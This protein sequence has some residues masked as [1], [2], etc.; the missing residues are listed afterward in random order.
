MWTSGH[1]SG[2]NQVPNRLSLAVGAALQ[3][4]RCLPYALRWRGVIHDL[5]FE[6]SAGD[7]G[8]IIDA[9]LERLDLLLQFLSCREIVWVFGG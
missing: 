9:R 8:Q 2:K 5:A 3:L 7:H 4:F 1:E 6:V